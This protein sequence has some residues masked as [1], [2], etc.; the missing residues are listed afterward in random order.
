MNCPKCQT[1]I[2]AGVKFCPE[3]GSRLGTTHG[4]DSD[5]SL[6]GLKTLAGEASLGQMAT[7]IIAPEPAAGGGRKMGERYEIRQEIGR[8]GFAI[9]SLAQ[10]CKL[11]REVA[12]KRLQPSVLEGI[13][14]QQLLER[15]QR[16]ASTIAALNHRNIVLVYDSDRDA[17]GAYVVMEYVDGGSLRELLKNRGGKLEVSEAVEIIKSVARG[18]A[19]AHRKN[20]VHRDIK[21]ANIL[22]SKE[23]GEAVP[24]IVDFGLAR[25][26]GES[27]LSLSGVGMG[28]PWYMPPE[29]RRN[30]KGVNHTA[31]LYALG[32]TLYELVTGEVPDTVELEKL[33]GWLRPIVQRCIK[34]NPEERYFSAEDLLKDLEKPPVESANAAT[35]AGSPAAD[36]CPAC[37]TVNGEAEKFCK[38]CGAG[39]NQ[40]CP[41]C[42]REQRT[43]VRFCGGCGSDV[44]G[45][46][47]LANHVEAMRR[48]A[49]DCRHDR[50]LKEAALLE[51]IQ[52]AARGE[53]GRKLLEESV[54]LKTTASRALAS[55]EAELTAVETLRSSGRYDEGLIRLKA[56]RQAGGSYGAK[57]DEKLENLWLALKTECAGAIEKLCAEGKVEDAIRR[58]EKIRQAQVGWGES[59]VERKLQESWNAM[60]ESQLQGFLSEGK[61]E[62]AYAV[63]ARLERLNGG[64]GK[65]QLELQTRLVQEWEAAFDREF[66]LLL[67]T[68]EYQKALEKLMALSWISTAEAKTKQWSEAFAGYLKQQGASRAVKESAFL[69]KLLAP[70]A[71]M[72]VSPDVRPSTDLDNKILVWLGALGWRKRLKQLQR[73]PLQVMFVK[74][75]L[76]CFSALFLYWL[77]GVYLHHRALVSEAAATQRQIQESVMTATK[78]SPF[79]NSLGMKFVPVSGTEV[80]FGVWDVRVQDYQVYAE[81]STSVDREWK[82]PGFTQSPDHPVVKVNWNDCM[83]FC[84]WLTQKERSE[85]K[86]ALDQKY[87]LPFDA[88]WSV[89]VGLLET[90]SGTPKDKDKKIRGQYPWN[91]S[92]PPQSGDGNYSP[93]FNVDNYE[94]TSPVGHFLANK[95]GLFDMGG[96]VW[97]W[98]FDLGGGQ[99]DAHVLRGASWPTDIPDFLLSSCRLR[100]S[101]VS[102]YNSNGFRCVLDCSSK[103][104]SKGFPALS[105]P[106]TIISK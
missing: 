44:P 27:E 49:Q 72:F 12:I 39:L 32:K 103:E 30:A 95:F 5:V 28:T 57:T 14:G 29:Q 71:T 9:V 100:I 66:G 96:N 3:C 1:E 74:I 99:S 58:I 86:I 92:W 55:L 6:G 11:G 83:A 42:G 13:Q 45:L 54:S 18:L 65:P 87:R 68:G 20:L 78:D 10:D 62:Q 23:G 34:N 43:A 90:S 81:S 16:E 106:Y 76:V 75:V 101:P 61:Y 26:G 46:A 63:L 8:G 82:N 64:L 24:K 52:F 36:Q 47:K 88:E 2:A 21:P 53:K 19:Y 56:A 85:G 73:A 48:Y 94:Y 35:P 59:A 84:E 105:E 33:P 50:L 37:G 60:L 89:A 15:F 80:L 41:E 98:C 51:A 102:R 7:Q 31:D 22:I 77:A 38:Q 25:M 93:M 40:P 4:H 79:V 104:I 70:P 17:E 97:Q 69:Q 67:A 91:R